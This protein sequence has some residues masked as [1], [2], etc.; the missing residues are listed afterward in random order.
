MNGKTPD[1][2]GNKYNEIM[3]C[4][5]E[6]LNILVKG[7]IQSCRSKVKRYQK[8]GEMYIRE[9]LAIRA[10]DLDEGVRK[11]CYEIVLGK[12]AETPPMAVLVESK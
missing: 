12:V 10:G 5:K 8:G 3:N 7:S 9:V 11:E 2:R 1:I 4:D 6:V